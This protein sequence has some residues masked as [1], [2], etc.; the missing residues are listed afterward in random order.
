MSSEGKNDCRWTAEICEEI[1]YEIEDL[2]EMS[3]PPES[4]DDTLVLMFE[5]VGES[6][7]RVDFKAYLEFFTAYEDARWELGL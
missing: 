1:D 2:T 3:D 5:V 4:L 7:R 6:I